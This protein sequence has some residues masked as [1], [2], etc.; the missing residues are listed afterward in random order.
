MLFDTFGTT[1]DW[2]GSLTRYCTQLGA[3]LGRETDWGALVTEWRS[4]YKPAIAPVREGKRAWLGFDELHRETLDS[5]LPKYALDALGDR[6][7]QRLV[8]GWHLLEGWPD[9][10]PGLL[11]L[12]ERYI[13]GAFSNGTTR[14]L[15]DMAK[16]AGFAWD[17]IFGADQFGTYKPASELYL[18]ALR[19]LA[20]SPECVV[21]VAAHNED[22]QA[23]ASHGIGTAF[24]YRSTE[25]PE[26]TGTYRFLAHDFYELATQLA[27]G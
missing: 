1:A 26:P 20:A 27:L 13:V 15:I 5:L 10:A 25:D 8:H 9:A 18:G 4:L 7:R 21:L 24:L 12:K 22:L 17:V 2:K 19:L 3:E 6:D 23:A 14:Q 16:H 11:K